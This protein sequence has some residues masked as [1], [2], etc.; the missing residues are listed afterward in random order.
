MPDNP[1]NFTYAKGMFLVPVLLYIMSAVMLLFIIPP[2]KDL[3]KKSKLGKFKVS[4]QK[5]IATIDEVTVKNNVRILQKSPVT[6]ICSDENGITYRSK[7][8][9]PYPRKYFAGAN[10]TVYTKDRKYVVD[11]DSVSESGTLKED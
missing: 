2:I 11:E 1:R 3:R 10:I 5:I 9:S 8:L 4:G 7:F 6:V